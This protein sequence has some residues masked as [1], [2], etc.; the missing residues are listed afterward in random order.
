MNAFPNETNSLW[1]DTR[2]LPFYI[3]CDLVHLLI[4]SKLVQTVSE[5]VVTVHPPK[6]ISSPSF[7]VF[8]SF[9]SEK[10]RNF[11]DYTAM[12]VKH[13]NSVGKNLNGGKQTS[14]DEIRVWHLLNRII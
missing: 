1:F 12:S 14:Q 4:N 7:C 3:T 8:G 11:T 13:L 9:P 5:R 10:S 6:L 2:F